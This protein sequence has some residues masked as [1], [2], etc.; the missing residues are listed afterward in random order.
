MILRAAFAACLVLVLT[1]CTGGENRVEEA[2][3]L[4]I[5]L[6]GNGDE[7]Q[8]LDPHVVTGLPEHRILS[9]LLEGLA[10][11]DPETGAPI[12]AAA[13]SW[14]I[15]DDQTVYTF[16]IRQNA[17]WSNGDPVTAQDFAFSWRR[18][19]SPKLATE[20][21]YMLWCI[22]NAQAFSEGKL[23]DFNEVGIR[24]V[25]DSTLEVTLEHPTPYFLSLHAHQSWFPVH[26][27]TI[28]RFGPVDQRGTKWTQPSSFVGNGPFVLDRWEPNR[29]LTVKKNPLY[30]D[31][32]NVRL[33]GVEFYPIQ[34]EQTE[35]RSFRVGELHMTQSVPMHKIAVY[36]REHPELLRIDPMFATYFY[37]FNCSKPPL[38]DARVRSAL[39]MAIDRKSIVEKVTK[40][41][42]PPAG[43]L[44]PHGVA[45]YAPPDGI[46]FDIERARQLLAEA[47]YPNGEGFPALDVLYNTSEG[48]KQVAEA[49]QQ[50]W[51][52]NLNVQVGLLNQD[53]K[54]Y[55]SSVNNL[56]YQI[57]RGSW[58][59]DYLD[60]NT[61]LDLFVTNGGNNRTGWSSAE[62]DRL[63]TEAA[64]TADAEK[65]NELF[66]TAEQ[67][68]LDEAPIMPIYTYTRTY[69]ISA[70]VKG[71]YPSLI[72]EIFFKSI[73]LE[74]QNGPTG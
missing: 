56:D 16:H 70:Q 68:L 29:I 55:L 52:N 24:V 14:T 65:R 26:R 19:L 33:N 48:H 3:R 44:T 53:W 54:V 46:P 59:G 50:M 45:G 47:G 13:E 57:A 39:A 64:R 23:T 49:V 5:L 4:G 40:G 15:S 10:A 21:A 17:C 35:E 62:Y 51:R 2:S 74:P 7:P 28:E 12:P 11:L 71:H 8:E 38:N 18:M 20:Y 25:D 73:Y 41:G 36:R 66:H 27:A 22:K 58:V 72:G 9:T 1:T 60:P 42:Q 32:A 30:W 67:I 34:S 69:L 37:R 43:Y 31:T 6:I 61:F 63:V